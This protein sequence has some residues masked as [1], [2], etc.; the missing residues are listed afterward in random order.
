M[1]Q[2][3]SLDLGEI[4]SKAQDTAVLTVLHPETGAETTMKITLYSPDCEECRL[5]LNR[6]QDTAMKTAV[7]RPK[8]K[9]ITAEEQ[10]QITLKSL[11]AV[12]AG[13]EGV[14]KNGDPLP[15]TE[16]NV[17]AVYEGFP[18]IREQVSSF[19]GDRQNFFKQ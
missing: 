18:W 15:F 9:I 3:I 6:L 13:W 19:Q 1:T 17:L 7:R 10:Q 11:V 4:S 2:A 14:V 12:T 16:D 8:G 5:R